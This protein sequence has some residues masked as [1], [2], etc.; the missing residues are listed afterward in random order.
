MTEPEQILQIV[1]KINEERYDEVLSTFF[2]LCFKS[3]GVSSV[4][5]FLGSPIWS[6]EDDCR[7]FDEKTNEF[8]PLENYLKKEMNK[9]VEEL[10]YQQ[11]KIE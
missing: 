2:S 8:E 3:D 10:Q 11:T 4:V 1:T 6:S 7:A 9:L 5:E